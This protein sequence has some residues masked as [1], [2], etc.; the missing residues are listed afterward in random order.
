MAGFVWLPVAFRVGCGWLGLAAA[1]SGWLGLA[2]G[3][4]GWLELAG[5]AWSWLGLARFRWGWLGLDR[6]GLVVTRWRAYRRW[7]D[8][9]PN[10]SLRSLRR[11]TLCNP[12]QLNSNTA[13]LSRLGHFE[14]LNLALRFF[15]L[16]LQRRSPCTGHQAKNHLNFE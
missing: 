16:Q 3:G 8:G 11:P 13:K 14:F 9:R 5:A 6:A 1:A 2:C 10:C 12:A 4:S 7:L 15:L